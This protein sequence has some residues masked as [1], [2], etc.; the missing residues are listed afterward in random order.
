MAGCN[1]NE[2]LVVSYLSVA[3]VPLL[4]SVA[5][6]FFQLIQAVNV[7]D[8]QPLDATDRIFHLIRPLLSLF[9]CLAISSYCLGN[10]V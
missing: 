4:L 7:P 9:L 8:Q 3:K 6:A 1:Q 10:P 5:L 2:S